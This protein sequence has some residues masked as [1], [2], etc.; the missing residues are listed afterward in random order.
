MSIVARSLTGLPVAVMSE[1]SLALGDGRVTNYSAT[2]GADSASTRW[3]AP[4][5][6]D[7]GGIA[8]ASVSA[9]IDG[10]LVL[11]A[12]VEIAPL[13][14]AVLSSSDIGTGER[15]VAVV[16]STAPIVVG[17]ELTDV[18]LHAQMVAVISGAEAVQLG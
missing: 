7:A 18:S 16:E 17:R 12:E 13:R 2:V 8:N 3:V 11:V 5:E 1:S 10:E 15:P 6:A 9:L 14:R 4:L